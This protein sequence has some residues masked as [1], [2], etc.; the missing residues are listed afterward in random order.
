MA[1]FVFRW[2]DRAAR[3]AL[4]LNNTFFSAFS[5]FAMHHHT[6]RVAK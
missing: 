4:W 1:E 3:F 2:S 6:K 5:I